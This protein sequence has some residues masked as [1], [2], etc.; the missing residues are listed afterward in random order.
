MTRQIARFLAAGGIAAA[1]NWGSRI[2][3]SHWMPFEAAVVAA[4]LVGMAIA[5]VLMRAFVFAAGERPV[6]VQAG[7]FALVNVAALAQTF[8]VSVLLARWILPALGVDDHA[9]AIAHLVGVAVPVATSF[10]GHR[11]YSFR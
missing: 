3:F 9:E 8:L 6:A 5:F 10:V 1:A 2:A 11:A 4:Y 7:R